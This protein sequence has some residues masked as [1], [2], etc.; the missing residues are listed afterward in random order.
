MRSNLRR[1]T[2]KL[3][4]A[5]PA[6]S[7]HDLPTSGNRSPN[8]AV[9]AIASAPSPRTGPRTVT[10][11]IGGKRF[12][13]TSDD[14]YIGQHAHGFEPHLVDLFRA[15]AAGSDVTLDIGANIGCT[16]L[17]LAQLSRTVHAFEPSPTTFAFLEQNVAR[18]GLT[19]IAVHNI[20]LGDKAENSTLTFAPN[21]RSG[22]F[23][24]NQTQ[25]SIG[26]TVEPIVIRPLDEI[27][28]LSRSPP[29]ID[30]GTSKV[31]FIKIDVEGFEPAVLR[32]ASRMLAAYQ[33]TVLMELNHWCLN[34]LQRTSVPDFFDFLRSLFPVLFAVDGLSTL[35]LHDT[36]DSYIVMYHHINRGRFVNIVAAF[37]RERLTT[38]L[39]K[40][41]EPFVLD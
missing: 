4:A 29:G 28:D 37:N 3:R 36:S 23:V 14:E 1:W 6:F 34:A 35:D 41:R 26:H 7:P 10:M 30:L 24:S 2:K 12:A 9:S 5:L 32:G 19:N 27:F 17:A 38:F 11:D 16:A 15:L 39:E 13:M 31:D 8:P 40:Y 18:A 20:A 21:N 33:P 22:G 25:A